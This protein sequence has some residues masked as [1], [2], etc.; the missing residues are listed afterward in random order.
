MRSLRIGVGLCFIALLF[1]C[2]STKPLQ[3][4][5]TFDYDI[6]FNFANVSSY[7]WLTMPGTS[8]ID[9][10]NQIR[11]QAAVAKELQPKGLKRTSRNPDV[12]IVMYGG[13]F[14]EVN[15]A[16]LKIDYEV[17]DV[18]RLKLALYD[19]KLKEEVWWGETRADL[20]YNMSAEKKDEI[21]DVA[22]KRILEYYP[23][24]R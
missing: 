10:F 3:Y 17:Y 22:V 2:Y 15:T 7:D 18:G 19:G 13:D 6:D 24:Q 4:E 21:I 9:R 23:P 14:R 16:V 12:F 5:V 1:S 8:K 11:I 20:F